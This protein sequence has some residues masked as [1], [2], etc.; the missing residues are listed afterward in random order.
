LRQEVLVTGEN[1]KLLKGFKRGDSKSTLSID[2]DF[3]NYE[4]CSPISSEVS[5][6]S[7]TCHRLDSPPSLKAFDTSKN[8]FPASYSQVNVTI[9]EEY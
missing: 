8:Y 6:S 2:T 9:S 4:S 7:D 1:T 5:S 3:K